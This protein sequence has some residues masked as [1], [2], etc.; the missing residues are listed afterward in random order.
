MS[1]SEKENEN[2]SQGKSK[3]RPRITKVSW[4]DERVKVLIASVEA[5]PMLWN[6]TLKDY[7]N[8]I[9]RD[10]VWKAIAEI[11]FENEISARE[12]NTKWQNLRCQYKEHVNKIKKKKS[13]QGTDENYAVRWKFLDSGEGDAIE[14]TSNFA[15]EVSTLFK[16]FGH[17]F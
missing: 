8:K 6:A 10:S 16:F 9:K 5:E 1:D 11:D 3:R 2:E 14:T 13:G 12:L 7:R 4:T 17:S 15:S